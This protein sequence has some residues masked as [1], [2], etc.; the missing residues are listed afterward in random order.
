MPNNKKL[1]SFPPNSKIINFSDKETKPMFVSAAQIHKLVLGVSAKTWANWRT[2]KI[3]PKY[4]VF[5]GR[6]YYRVSDI[7]DV[8]TQYPVQTFS[9]N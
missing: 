5:N 9:N 1:N 7:E 6:V 2:Q 3:G 4:Y 8:L